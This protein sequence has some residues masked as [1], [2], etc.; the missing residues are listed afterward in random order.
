M[1]ENLSFDDLELF[2]GAGERLSY[3]FRRWFERVSADPNDFEPTPTELEELRE[4]AAD[5][6]SG[7]YEPPEARRDQIVDY[8]EYMVEPF[9]SMTEVKD[10]LD[11]S[12]SSLLHYRLTQQYRFV[13]HPNGQWHLPHSELIRLSNTYRPK[14]HQ[15]RPERRGFGKA[16]TKEEANP[17]GVEGGGRPLHHQKHQNTAQ[18]QQ[19]AIEEVA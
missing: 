7:E 10:L 15:R 2:H 4:F 14:Y 5:W 6:N 19:D 12:D 11:I 1:Q 13:I 8:C 9:W 16:N 18:Q 3:I 17:T